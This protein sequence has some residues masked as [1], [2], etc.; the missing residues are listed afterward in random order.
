[1][2]PSG[3]GAEI[4]PVLPKKPSLQPA[5]LPSDGSN[6]QIHPTW[7]PSR[8]ASGVTFTPCHFSACRASPG[9]PRT[10]SHCKHRCNPTAQLQP[11][12]LSLAVICCCSIL[13]PPPK[14]LFFSSVCFS[15][16]FCAMTECYSRILEPLWPES[17]SRCN[18]LCLVRL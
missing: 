18:Y 9:P 1:M 14:Y 4:L 2:P 6:L 5:Q 3:A 15:S 7:I 10:R 8:R 11:S 16:N 17:P 13:L 12:F